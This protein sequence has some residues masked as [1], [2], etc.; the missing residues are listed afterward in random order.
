MHVHICVTVLP[1]LYVVLDFLFI[2]R[3]SDIKE[4]TIVNF[5]EVCSLNSLYTTAIYT[6]YLLYGLSNIRKEKGTTG[7]LPSKG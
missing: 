1:E 4:I 3:N 7:T 6:G 5:D 2:F